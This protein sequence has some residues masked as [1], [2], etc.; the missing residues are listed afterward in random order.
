VATKMKVDLRIKNKLKLGFIN[1]KEIG[2]V[3]VPFMIALLAL[4][5]RSVG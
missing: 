4:Y 5:W 1:V 3:I 2:Y